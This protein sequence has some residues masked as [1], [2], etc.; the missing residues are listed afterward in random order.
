MGYAEKSGVTSI[1]HTNYQYISMRM[2]FR[3]YRS[4]NTGVAGY[5]EAFTPVLPGFCYKKVFDMSGKM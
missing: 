5:V 3:E 2:L 1:I 4:K